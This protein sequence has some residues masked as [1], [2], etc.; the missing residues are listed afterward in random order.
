MYIYTYLNIFDIFA[1]GQPAGLGQWWQLW[2]LSSWERSHFS[3]LTSTS[4]SRQGDDNSVDLHDLEED[5]KYKKYIYDLT[6]FSQG[7]LKRRKTHSQE[8]ASSIQ[9]VTNIQIFSDTCFWLS[10]QYSNIFWCFRL[11]DKYSNVFWYMFL[12]FKTFRQ[13]RSAQSSTMA[14]ADQEAL[15]QLVTISIS[16][17]FSK[18]NVIGICTNWTKNCICGDKIKNISMYLLFSKLNIIGRSTP[19]T[20]THVWSDLSANWRQN[21]KI[22]FDKHWQLFSNPFNYSLCKS[23]CTRQFVNLNMSQASKKVALEVLIIQLTKQ[24]IS[25][26]RGWEHIFSWQRM[27]AYF[28]LTED[29]SIFLSP[30]QMSE[31]SLPGS[32]KVWW[33]S[34]NKSH[35]NVE[36]RNQFE[37]GGSVTKSEF[38]EGLPD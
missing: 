33:T 26:D 17:L 30:F 18:L 37:K 8:Q 16:L 20:F 5:E 29:E 13:P 11:F 28:Q 34:Y 9:S 19:W 32:A 21:P 6:F 31:K 23:I 3:M 38:L 14:V 24:L 36:F 35:T 22:R 15:F 25:V 12:T 7:S 1:A 27:R 2:A 4:T 10:N